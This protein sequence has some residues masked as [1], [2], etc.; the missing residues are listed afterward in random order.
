MSLHGAPR[1]PAAR[2]QQGLLSVAGLG[3]L[4]LAGCGVY[5]LLKMAHAHSKHARVHLLVRSI[6]A[7]FP[8][9]PQA[10]Q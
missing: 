9:T 6:A 2:H 8:A 5:L 10:A 1:L 4:V 3:W 7:A